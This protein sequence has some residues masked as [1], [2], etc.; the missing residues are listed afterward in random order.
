[1]LMPYKVMNKHKIHFVKKFGNTSRI[2]IHLVLHVLLSP[3]QVVGEWLMKRQISF[4]GAWLKLMHVLW[5]M[6]LWHTLRV[7]DPLE[8][9]KFILNS[10]W[11]SLNIYGNCKASCR[12]FLFYMLRSMSH[13]NLC[14]CVS[15]IVIWFEL[16]M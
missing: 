13:R 5:V 16:C 15:F 11:T 9:E 10:G 4:V 14:E 2:T 8:T 1:M 12:N 7:M 3:W 6:D